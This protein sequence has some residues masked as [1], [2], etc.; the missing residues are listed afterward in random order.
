MTK[1]IAEGWERPELKGVNVGK[2][3]CPRIDM[4]HRAR[5]RGDKANTRAPLLRGSLR[6]E[7][8]HVHYFKKAYPQ[9]GEER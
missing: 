3:Q 1:R 7:K 2:L 6:G 5:T 8:E 4:G 9:I